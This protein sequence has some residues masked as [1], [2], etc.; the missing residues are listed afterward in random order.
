MNKKCRF[1]FRP[2][3]RYWHVKRWQ[4][5][6][7]SGERR[8][9]RLKTKREAESIVLEWG[10]EGLGAMMGQR[11]PHRDTG[12]LSAR[13]FQEHTLPEKSLSQPPATALL[14]SSLSQS[15]PLSLSSESG[16]ARSFSLQ[17]WT[18]LWP[19]EVERF[20]KGGHI[21]EVLPGLRTRRQLRCNSAPSMHTS[22]IY[23]KRD[24]YQSTAFDDI[25]TQSLGREMW[26]CSKTLPRWLYRD[27]YQNIA[28]TCLKD[29]VSLPK[30]STLR[31]T[32]DVN[33]G[34]DSWKSTS[35]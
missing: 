12:L 18:N 33:H 3:P 9:N 22:H 29:G 10:L 28:Q 21:A 11:P 20:S 30:T 27:V 23:A 34:L 17:A 14:H 32:W 19:P 25:G 13:A 5:A 35:I 16:E 8:V 7:N 1:C 24:T 6:A 26:C 2:V 4:R 15:A 31:T